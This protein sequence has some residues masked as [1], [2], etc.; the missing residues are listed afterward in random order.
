MMQASQQLMQ[1][2]A[3]SYG[4]KTPSPER[5]H[6][7]V[8]LPFPMH[9]YPLVISLWLLVDSLTGLMNAILL[10]SSNLIR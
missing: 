2:R 1:N 6:H 8:I 5:F 9:K 7:P 4:Y 3:E 10:A